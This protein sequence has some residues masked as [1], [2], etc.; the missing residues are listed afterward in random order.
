M[1]LRILKSFDAPELLM[2]AAGSVLVVLSA[3]F[4]F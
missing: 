3:A 4:L 2:L 1:L